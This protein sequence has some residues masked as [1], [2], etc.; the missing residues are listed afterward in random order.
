LLGGVVA[1]QFISFT[2][3]GD[4]LGIVDIDREALFFTD[5]EVQPQSSTMTNVGA[6][7][8]WVLGI[9]VGQ[10]EPFTFEIVE[11]AGDEPGAD[12]PCEVDLRLANGESCTITVRPI[13]PTRETAL[14]T[15]DVGPRKGKTIGDESVVLINA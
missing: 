2:D 7:A 6:D 8:V 3:P 4:D 5:G 13:A 12:P 9:E 10:N 11:Q 1:A 14:L 15:I